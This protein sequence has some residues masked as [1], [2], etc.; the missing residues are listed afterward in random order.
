MKWFIKRIVLS[1][2]SGDAEF[3]M[4]VIKAIDPERYHDLKYGDLKNP[5]P[6]VSPRLARIHVREGL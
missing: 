6:P 2:F 1:L 4:Q 3:R 5:P